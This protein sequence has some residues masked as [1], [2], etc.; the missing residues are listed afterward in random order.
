MRKSATRAGPEAER[1]GRQT[2]EDRVLNVDGPRAGY[3]P[4]GR[5]CRAALTVSARMKTAKPYWSAPR[6]EKTSQGKAAALPYLIAQTCRSGVA[7]SPFR[8]LHSE[9]RNHLVAVRKD[10]ITKRTQIYWEQ[11]SADLPGRKSLTTILN[12]KPIWVRLASFCGPRAQHG[13]SKPQLYS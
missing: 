10:Q 2:P 4:V 7:R 8:T 3:D 13:Q 12:A 11:K 6:V 1:K 9:F 5:R